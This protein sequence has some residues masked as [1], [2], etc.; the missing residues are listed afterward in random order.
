MNVHFSKF[1]VSLFSF[2]ESKYSK[3]KIYFVE[4]IDLFHVKISFVRCA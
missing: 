3:V 2:C 4:R 1:V